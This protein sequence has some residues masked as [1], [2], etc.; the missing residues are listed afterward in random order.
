M[1]QLRIPRLSSVHCRWA[2]LVITLGLMNSNLGAPPLDDRVQAKGT[3]VKLR[4]PRSL[5]VE[6]S[7]GPSPVRNWRDPVLGLYKGGAPPD[8]ATIKH[9]VAYWC[10]TK[11]SRLPSSRK[12]SLPSREALQRLL[13]YAL[14]YP[15]VLPKLLGHLGEDGTHCQKVAEIFNEGERKQVF[16]ERQSK[17][18]KDWL[19]VRGNYFRD[20]LVKRAQA[21][22]FRDGWIQGQDEL[23]ALARFDWSA[24]EPVITALEGRT[25]LRIQALCLSLKYRRSSGGENDGGAAHRER[26]KTIASDTHAPGRARSIAFDALMG[27]AWPGRD[28]WFL[29]KFSD[30]S[31]LSL[32]DGHYGFSP[33]GDPVQSSPDDW[34]PRVS[35]LISGNNRAAHNNAARVL[36]GFNREE[37]RA[38]ALRPLVPWLSDPN[39]AGDQDTSR[40]DRL[41]LIQSMDRVELPECV[42]GLIWVLE[43]STEPFEIEGAATG[44]AHFKDPRGVAPMKGAL[45]RLQSKLF[46]SIHSEVLESIFQCRGFSDEELISRV[47]AYAVWRARQQ[48]PGLPMAP[49][50]IDAGRLLLGG[51]SEQREHLAPL[52]VA[53]VKAL[54]PNQPK[55]ASAIWGLINGWDQAVIDQERISRLSSGEIDAPTLRAL[56]GDANRIRKTCK[57]ELGT[58]AAFGGWRKGLVAAITQDHDLLHSVLVGEDRDSVIALLACAKVGLVPIPV[59]IVVQR[60]KSPVPQI[61]KASDR[62][63]EAMDTPDAR[64][65]FWNLHQGEI[66]IVGLPSHTAFFDRPIRS[67]EESL[68]EE[69]LRDPDLL[70]IVAFHCSSNWGPGPNMVL[71]RTRKG[72][73]IA[74]VNHPFFKNGQ[75]PIPVPILDAD[76]F[77]LYLREHH[78]DDLPPLHQ[79]VMDGP[80]WVYLHLTRD[81]GKRIYMN[82]PTDFDGAGSEYHLLIDRMFELIKQVPTGIHGH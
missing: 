52:L 12:E 28:E 24:A 56:M 41:R 67:W 45:S 3:T 60:A 25:D 51:S 53:R 13:A 73:S 57:S 16:Q 2:C 1:N 63:L 10:S 39:W 72:A 64:L 69:M 11:A 77:L 34:I 48:D 30:P 8:D 38:D 78:I 14:D 43:H 62:Y 81:G 70:E 47:E 19:M 71:R 31:L 33:L 7:E 40:S 26:L 68:R 49:G 17:E 21:T 4:G 79:R 36:A 76:A 46:P 82:E 66:R 54:K 55:R 80:E 65:A 9:L 5:F 23:E 22:A 32:T 74:G 6:L 35:K 50:A 18:I 42:P 59:D 15:E 20:E 29:S 58:L 75:G 27:R 37:S 44:I 61:A